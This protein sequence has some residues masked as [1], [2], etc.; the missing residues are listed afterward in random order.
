MLAVNKVFKGPKKENK[1]STKEW[2]SSHD[3]GSGLYQVCFYDFNKCD[4]NPNPTVIEA[5]NHTDYSITSE[6]YDSGKPFSQL[7]LEIPAE[8][9]DD[10]AIA[11]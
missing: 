1:V 9:F 6:E 2:V 3:Y 5:E 7:L 10:I 11:W 4:V 8:R